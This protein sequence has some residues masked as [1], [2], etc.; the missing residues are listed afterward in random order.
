MTPRRPRDIRPTDVF[1]RWAFGDGEPPGLVADGANAA[2]LGRASRPGELWITGM[3]DDPAVVAGLVERLDGEHHVDGVTVTEDAFG[4]LTER[5]R[6]PAP[7]HWCYWVLDPAGVELEPTIAVPL[8]MDDPRIGP[9]LEHSDSAYTFPGNPRMVRWAGVVEGGDLPCVAGQV[10]DPSGAA[11]LVSV[12][13]HPSARGRGLARQACVA[14]MRAAIADG[15]PMIVLEMY[16]ANEPGRRLYSSL[17][18]TEVGRFLSGLLAHALPPA[19][20]A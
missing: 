8:A 11:H 2:W 17:G 6:S 7:G 20:T 18:F 12:C 15:A 13:T 4:H 5:L 1:I 14:I 19:D 3:G 10:R 9:L 16:V